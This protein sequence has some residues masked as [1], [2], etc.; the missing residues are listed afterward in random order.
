MS[1]EMGELTQT[2]LQKI[3]IPH[4]GS[5]SLLQRRRGSSIPQFTNSPTMVI[6]VGLPARG[7]T[8]ISTKLTRYLNWIGTPT[9]VFNLG[10][11]RREAVSYR[12][13][14]FFHPD[15]TEA[16]LIR[17]QCALAALKDVHKYLSRE[18]GHVAVFDATNTTRERRSLILQF[19]KEHGYKVFFIES[20]CNDPDIIA[21]N[22]K[23][24]K[25]GSPDYIDCDKEKVLED[26]LKRIECYEINYQPLDEE[27]DSKSLEA[28]LCMQK[29]QIGIKK[30]GSVLG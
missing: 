21:E 17:K 12:N 6:M 15:N 8:Y 25:L 10:Q 1:Q 28:L 2:R 3:W 14:E 24:V 29:E 16:Q 5:S 23:Q 13:Y 19:A 27:L 30:M 26:F 20:I 18:E 22:I 7:K 11:Y 9:K 4:S